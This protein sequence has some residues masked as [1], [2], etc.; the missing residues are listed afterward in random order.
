MG[1]KVLL[2]HPPVTAYFTDFPTPEPPLGLA[3][4]AAFMESR[5]YEVSVLDA[6][7][8]GINNVEHIGDRVRVGLSETQITARIRDLRPAVVGIGAAYSS[9]AA[10]SHAVAKLVKQVDPAI[11]VVAGGAHASALPAMVLHDDNIDVVVVGEGEVTF[12]E[13]VEAWKKGNGI[14]GIP[15]TVVRE[16]SGVVVN[17]QRKFID[18]LDDLPFPA[19]HLL[20][21]DVYAN[22]PSFI[23]D[24][25]MRQPRTTMISSRGCPRNC[26]FCSNHSVWRHVWR[27]RSAV[28]VVDEI[29]LLV[30]R[31]HIREIAFMDDNLTLNKQRMMQICDEIIKRKIDIKWS[32]PNGVA[33]WT[34]DEEMLDKMKQSGCWKLTFGIES[35]APETQDF[36]G[37]KIDL[38]MADRIIRYANKIGMWTHST[39][40]I[41]FPY[42][43]MESIQKT[44]DYSLN[45]DLD[46]AVFFIASPYPGSRLYQIYKDEGFMIDDGSFSSLVKPNWRTKSLTKVQLEQVLLKA[47]SG[48]V[49]NRMRKFMNPLRIARKVKSWDD[50]RFVL[51]MVRTTIGVQIVAKRYG[52]IQHHLVSSKQ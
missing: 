11:L 18:N 24:Y 52:R 46:I 16:E 35:A 42:E 27:Q 29:E 6:L 34:L 12:L 19:R 23:R 25:S 26:V 38:D 30:D 8:L 22:R 17:P 3:Y 39:F 1:T 9:L 14:H 45:S 2:I 40:V 31:Y 50:L 49:A 37:K 15:G 48:F 5:G 33:I 21:M 10:D 13:V 32:T 41:G 4:I 51:K 44:I 7:S 20:P 28:S 47:S 43:T 36:I